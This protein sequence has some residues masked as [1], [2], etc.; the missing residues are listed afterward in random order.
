MIAPP[1][2]FVT[3]ETLST[4]SGNTVP[5]SKHFRTGQPPLTPRYAPAEESGDR[6]DP[7]VMLDRMSAAAVSVVPVDGYNRIR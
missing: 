2:N 3:R 4:K 5:A 7:Y 6:M 1:R